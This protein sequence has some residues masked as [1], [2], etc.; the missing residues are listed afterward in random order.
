[1]NALDE[2]SRTPLHRSA[3]NGHV[4][5]VRFLIAKGTKVNAKSDNGITPLH[6]AADEGNGEVVQLLIDNGADVNAKDDDG[7][8]P[9]YY[10]GRH[11]EV[12]ALL[13]KHGAKE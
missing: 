1:V 2:A 9:L 12:R 3:A 4:A 5:I 10:A 7:R 6:F 11:T 13:L 8:T